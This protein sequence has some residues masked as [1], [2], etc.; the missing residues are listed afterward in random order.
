MSQHPPTDPDEGLD[1]AAQETRVR[2]LERR[3]ESFE[4]FESDDLGGFDTW[5]WI[6]CVLGAVVIPLIAV[7]WFAG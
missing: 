7:W 5:D 4:A 6:A 2:D 3:I 1:P